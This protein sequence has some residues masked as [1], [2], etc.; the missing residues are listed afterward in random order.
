MYAVLF[1][2]QA[3][4]K[5]LNEKDRTLSRAL[6]H[7]TLLARTS[8]GCRVKGLMLHV[9]KENNIVVLKHPPCS[10]D[11]AMNSAQGPP[12]D[13]ESTGNPP[14]IDHR[15]NHSETSHRLICVSGSLAPASRRRSTKIRARLQSN[16][17]LPTHEIKI[18]S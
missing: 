17:I 6:A 5:E 11:L 3:R 14:F 10:S 12:F 9:L 13:D 8:A 1:E 7:T 4:S 2:L 15:R 16:G 18:Q